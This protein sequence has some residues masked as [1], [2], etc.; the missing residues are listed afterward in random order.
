M[1][2]KANHYGSHFAAKKPKAAFRLTAKTSGNPFWN[3]MVS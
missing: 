1:F 3:F 2:G